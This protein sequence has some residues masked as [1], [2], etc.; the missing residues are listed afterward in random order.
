MNHLLDSKK[1]YAVLNY[2]LNYCVFIRH[3]YSSTIGSLKVKMNERDEL[4]TTRNNIRKELEETKIKEENNIKMIKELDN[5]LP[6]Q[7]DKNVESK[8]ELNNLRNEIA[9]LKEEFE[10]LEM[11]LIELK[12]ELEKAKTLTVSDEE[13]QSIISTKE[14]VEKELEEQN[15]FTSIN[16]QKLQ[17]NSRAIKEASEITSMMDQVLVRLSGF[18]ISEVKDL[19]KRIDQLKID[20]AKLKSGVAQKKTQHEHKSHIMESKKN[21]IAYHRNKLADLKIQQSAKETA[22][23]KALKEKKNLHRKLS[24]EEAALSVT[25]KQLIEDRDR[26]YR[27]TANVMKQICSNLFEDD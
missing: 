10:K 27:L 11:D 6:R 13:V 14:A 4:R 1:T 7:R 2:L 8:E 3:T 12:N 25:Y 24:P 15:Q 20:L 5:K 18:D 19:R 9:K 21:S 23:K 22:L 16:R 26:A 17:D